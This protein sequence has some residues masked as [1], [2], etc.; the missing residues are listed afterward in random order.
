M[1][2]LLRLDD[3]AP[4]DVSRVF[5]LA[6]E[7]ARGGCGGV[8]DGRNFALFFPESGVRTR[9]AFESGIRRL[10]G[11][12]VLLPSLALDKGENLGDVAG[13]LGQ[14]VDGLVVRHP[15]IDVLESLAAADSVPVVNAMTALNHPC[16]VLSDVY[17]LSQSHGDPAQLRVLFVGGAGNIAG[18]WAEAARIFGFSLTQCCPPGFELGQ[19][20][21]VYKLS[22]ALAGVNVV[23]TDAW[24]EGCFDAFGAYQVTS[25]LLALA[26]SDVVL[27]PCPPF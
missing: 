16:E 4:E 13:Y 11:D 3:W 21:V 7:I 20:P 14:W 19:M 22:D 8:L 23:V 10:G 27:N 17:A 9:V 6:D 25:P 24:P 2:H 15:R 5:A 12:C 26:S 18:A 1:Q